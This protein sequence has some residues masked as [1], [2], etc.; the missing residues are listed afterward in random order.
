MLVLNPNGLR[1]TNTK[2][3]NMLIEKCKEMQIDIL[4]MSEVNMKWTTINKEKMTKAMKK[5]HQNI[6]I[7]YA[8]SSDQEATKSEQ[9][10][11]GIMNVL[12]RSIVECYNKEKTIID[13]LEKWT[14]I[15]FTKNNKI[16]RIITIYRMPITS[17][18]RTYSV[19]T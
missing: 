11:G 7:V 16:I 13:K 5:M 9:L 3:L 17:S 4:L 1:T 18:H 12:S 6:E 2:K 10:P 14:S 15:Q 8:D 19:V